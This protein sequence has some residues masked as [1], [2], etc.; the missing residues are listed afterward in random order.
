MIK[1]GTCKALADA[2]IQDTILYTAVEDYKFPE[3]ILSKI[4]HFLYLQLI[5]DVYTDKAHNE[6]IAPAINKLKSKNKD[7]EKVLNTQTNETNIFK[8]NNI[9]ILNLRD[10]NLE[11]KKTIP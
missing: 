5:F 10:V 3:D 7:I 9:I 4:I 6:H 11:M 2:E 1:G 8:S